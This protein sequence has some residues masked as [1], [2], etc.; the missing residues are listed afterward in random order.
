MESNIQIA[1]TGKTFETL[2][3]MN[4]KYENI[5]KKKQKRPPPK[6]LYNNNKEK[7]NNL[8]SI[9]DINI[10]DNEENENLE[11]RENI[12]NIDKMIHY[13]QFHE[14]FRLILKYCSIYARC[15]PDNKTQIIESLQKE[16]LTVLMCGDGANDCG[17]LKV[18]DVGISLS[19]EEAS[20]AAPFTSSIPDISCVIEVLKEGKCA[21]VTSFQI[22]KFIILYSIIQFISVTFLIIL[23]SYLSDWQFL[24]EDVFIITPLGFLM[25]LTPAYDKLTYHRPVSSLFSFSIIFS[26]LLQSL[27]VTGFQI[28]IYFLIDLVF[29][30]QDKDFHNNFCG[31]NEEVCDE[32]FDNFRKCSIFEEYEDKNCIDN[33]ALFYISFAQYLILCIVF[34]KGKPFKKSIFHNLPLFIFSIIIFIYTEYIVFYVDKFSEKKIKIIPF[35]DDYFYYK[36]KSIKPKY[37]IQFKF[38]VMIIIIINFLV[39]LFIEKIIVSKATKCWNK[40]KMNSLKNSINNDKRNEENL[41]IINKVQN[42]VK[43]QKM[44]KLLK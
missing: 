16:S 8:N 3:R 17:A 43:E 12:E 18:A 4:Q 2:Y 22:F 33:S 37:Y 34:A 31:E 5:I 21:L 39:S 9:N 41:Y 30:K 38:Y 27:N 40:M 26:M 23:D 24:V 20:I 14:A 10:E 25:P 1:I 42:Y 15:S 36:D 29:P 28:L 11:N 44:K 19:T 13:E 6:K 7:N 32:E 35:P